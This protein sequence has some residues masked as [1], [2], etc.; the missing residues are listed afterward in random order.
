MGDALPVRP[1]PDVSILAIN[2]GSAFGRV[3]PARP[4]RCL[5]DDEYQSGSPRRPTTSETDGM[6]AEALRCEDFERTTL[7]FAHRV[8]RILGLGKAGHHDLELGRAAIKMARIC[9]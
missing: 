9:A 3:A 5:A 7:G 2:Q 8:Q 1:K 4:L 6:C